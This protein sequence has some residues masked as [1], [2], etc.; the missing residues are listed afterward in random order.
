M[1]LLQRLGRLATPGAGAAGGHCTS[2]GNMAA[3]AGHSSEQ[4]SAPALQHSDWHMDLA[5]CCSQTAR[6]SGCEAQG[7]RSGREARGAVPD[8]S[9]LPRSSMEEQSRTS[10]HTGIHHNSARQV[11]VQTPATFPAFTWWFLSNPGITWN[12]R[13]YCIIQQGSRKAGF[14]TC[15]TKQRLS[16]RSSELMLM[17]LS[18]DT[19]RKKAILCTTW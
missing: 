13:R 17:S 10:L 14:V 11:T 15:N 7:L 16:N 2:A 19:T 8:L 4:L 3:Q 6:P 5:C 12:Y 18:V 9:T 1:T